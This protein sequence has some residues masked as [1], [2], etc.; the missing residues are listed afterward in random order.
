MILNII[1]L[2]IL[3]QSCLSQ[4]ITNIE[5]RI[6]HHILK[7]YNKLTRPSD[8]V[9]LGIELTLKQIISLEPD[10]LTSSSNLHIHWYDKRLKWNLKKFPISFITLQSF[11]IW[12]PFDLFIINNAN[13]NSLFLSLID[14]N[15]INNNNYFYINHNGL[16]SVYIGLID[17]KTKCKMNIYKYPFDEQLCSIQIGSWNLINS[18]IS[19]YHYNN[20]SSSSNNLINNST[21]NWLITDQSVK[22]LNT[23]R[24]NNATSDIY[25]YAFR[26][27]RKLSIS[28]FII[29][30]LPFVLLNFI[31]LVTFFMPFI[32]QIILIILIIL[33]LL[34]KVYSINNSYNNNNNNQ[35]LLPLILLNYL[36]VI[37]YTLIILIWFVILNHFSKSKKYDYLNLIVFF[38][39]VLM[40]SLTYLI[41][42]LNLF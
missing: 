28:L 27:K 31:S 26:L 24:I 17:L 20:S 41:I 3:F 22:I 1:I 25:N 7:D 35:E 5:D 42:Y 6:K 13:T 33:I 29:D 21:I 12:Y 19:I 9:S 8:K 11:Q 16:V 37:F 39:L 38:I 36:L 18:I 14:L 23:T 15:N 10:I 32:T 30:Y 34:L 2:I 40:F 4:Y